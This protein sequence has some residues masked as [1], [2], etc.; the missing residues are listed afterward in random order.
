M[1]G[2]GASLESMGAGSVHAFIHSFTCRGSCIRAVVAYFVQ[3]PKQAFCS[4]LS[5]FSFFLYPASFKV[6]LAADG[7]DLSS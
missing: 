1:E 2:Q 6:E 3:K 4:F 5:L 7:C